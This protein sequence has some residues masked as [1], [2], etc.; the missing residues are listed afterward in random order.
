MSPIDLRTAPRPAAADRLVVA[1]LVADP[2]ATA[3]VLGEQ[4]AELGE[5][6]VWDAR[7]GALVW[8]DIDG[9]AVHRWADGDPARDSVLSTTSAVGVAWPT[10]SGGLLLATADGLAVHDGTRLGPATRPDDM[11]ADYRFNDGACDPAGRFW[12]STMPRSGSAGDGVVHRVVA[13]DGGL[14]VTTQITGVPLGNGLVWSPDG[15][16]MYL[17]DT[18]AK[19]LYRLPYDVATGTPGDPEP[20]LAFAEDG[21]GPD[22]TTVDAEGGLW[23]AL[24]GGG[25]V[26]RFDPDGTPRGAYAVPAPDV[27]C[28]GFGAPGS[29][30]LYVTTASSGGSGTGGDALPGP[31]SPEDEIGGAVFHVRV[32]VDGLPV[33]PFADA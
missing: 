1:D 25:H 4:R 21:P 29:G 17:T 28:A 24:Y 7:A 8:V 13:G 9:R 23:V 31:S 16:T 26:L 5:R 2:V 30:D 20:L 33:R 14:E 12:V 32:D 10:E 11:P 3:R 6:P 19:V 27:T 18:D 15:T 22:G